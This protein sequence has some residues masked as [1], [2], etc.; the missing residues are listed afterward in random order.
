MS[1]KNNPTPSSLLPPSLYPT[2]ENTSDPSLI[3]RKLVT[4]STPGSGDSCR[5]FVFKGESHTLGNALKHVLLTNPKVTFAG[6]SIPHPAEDQM[7]LRIQTVDGES[8]QDVL[9]QGLTD[10]KA[11]CVVTKQKFEK[12]F[13]NYDKNQK[14]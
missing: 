7:F 6:Y 5:T 1:V 13:K 3:K 4:L 2:A 12:E 11:A 8:A 14:L 9:R 10:L